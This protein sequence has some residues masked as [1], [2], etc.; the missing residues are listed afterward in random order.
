MRRRLVGLSQLSHMPN[1]E[2]FRPQL[3]MKIRQST[4][5]VDH[6]PLDLQKYARE[7]YTVSIKVVFYFAAVSTLLAYLVRMPVCLTFLP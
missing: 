3:I 5:F 4:N 6:L 2:L 7:S 1:T